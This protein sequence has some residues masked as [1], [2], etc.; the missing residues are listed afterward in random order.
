MA[1][2]RA[3]L[4]AWGCAILYALKAARNGEDTTDLEASAR[5]AIQHA[6]RPERRRRKRARPHRVDPATGHCG[7]CD[8]AMG[9]S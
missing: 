1:E 8:D 4:A 3:L 2:G 9:V 7:G 5:F 6:Q